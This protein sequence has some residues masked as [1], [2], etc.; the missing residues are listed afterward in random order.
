[1]VAAVAATLDRLEVIGLRGVDAA[2]AGAGT[3]D[4]DNQ[5]RQFAPGHIGD[6]LLL[7]GDAGAGG[8]GHGPHPAGARAE[9]HVD[10]GDF[11]LGLDERAAERGQFA[12]HIFRDIALRGDRIAEVVAAAGGDRPHRDRFIS[13]DEQVLFFDSSPHCSPA[14]RSRKTVIAT[15]GHIC[16]Q[17]A[18]EEQRVR[19]SAVIRAGRKPCLLS[20][21]L[22]AIRPRGQAIVQSA[23]PL[24]RLS[25]MMILCHWRRYPFSFAKAWNL[26]DERPAVNPQ[27]GRRGTCPGA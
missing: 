1:M 25:S 18:Q 21:S 4:V 15:S 24:Q 16:A 14:L 3:G 13:L 9:Q 22:S 19:S 5:P 7:Q 11:A 2:Q 27:A 23:H 12:R 20:W 10:R 6:P 26:P 17:R 8:G